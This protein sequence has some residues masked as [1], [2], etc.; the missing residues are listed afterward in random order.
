MF[1]IIFLSTS[2]TEDLRLSDFRLPRHLKFLIPAIKTVAIIR[3]CC[4]HL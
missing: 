4:G 1:N 3:L 2:F